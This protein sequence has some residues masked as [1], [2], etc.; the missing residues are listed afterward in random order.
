MFKTDKHR[1]YERLDA[2]INYLREQNK[3]LMDRLLALTEKETYREIKYNENQ[4]ALQKK[5][6]ELIRTTDPV[7][8]KDKREK[9][10]KE[11]ELVNIQLRQMMTGE[12]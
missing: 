8:L 2:E 5:E 11:D 4:D 7:I 1:L 12:A 9:E 10:A 3:D 6:L